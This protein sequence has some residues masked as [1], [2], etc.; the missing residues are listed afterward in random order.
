MPELLELGH[1]LDLADHGGR[2]AVLGEVLL[3]LGQARVGAEALV[4]VLLTQQA[5]L[6]PERAYGDLVEG[7]DRADVD[8]LSVDQDPARAPAIGDG[9]CYTLHADHGMTLGDVGIV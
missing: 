4:L 1:L 8:P 9:N 7:R 2:V 3:H 5:D 6:E